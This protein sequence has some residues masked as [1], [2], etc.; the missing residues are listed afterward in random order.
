MDFFQRGKERIPL[1][2]ECG[3]HFD[4]TLSCILRGKGVKGEKFAGARMP[5][6]RAGEKHAGGQLRPC[7]HLVSV[8]LSILTDAKKAGTNRSNDILP[9]ESTLSCCFCYI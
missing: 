6:V 4:L 1:G 3:R 9:T 8:T 5:M 7:Y 2:H